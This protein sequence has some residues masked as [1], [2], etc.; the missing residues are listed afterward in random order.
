MSF[1][2]SQAASFSPIGGTRAIKYGTVDWST[3]QR[4]YDVTGGSDLQAHYDFEPTV[5]EMMGEGWAFTTRYSSQQ[6]STITLGSVAI[7]PDVWILRKS[8]PLYEISGSSPN[9]G[10]SDKNATWDAA[11]PTFTLQVQGE[12]LE[13][14]GPGLREKNIATTIFAEGIGTLT[15]DSTTH[16]ES[17]RMSNRFTVG[18]KPKASFNGKIEGKCT[19]AGTPTDGNDF[20]WLLAPG[21]IHDDPVKGLFTLNTGAETITRSAL[22]Y[23]VTLK[24]DKALRGGRV[25]VSSKMRVDDGS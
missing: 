25:T 10:E 18:G 4:H 12:V 20:R 17:F 24:W 15:W 3:S 22:M 5:E 16:V 21:G 23:D 9:F 1:P 6:Q 11:P 13:T 7:H 2:H 19:V 8:W 14:S